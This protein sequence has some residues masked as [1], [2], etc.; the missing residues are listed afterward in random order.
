MTK[1]PDYTR[2]DQTVVFLLF[3][4]LFL[5]AALIAGL[6]ILNP[7]LLPLPLAGAVIAILV[8]VAHWREQQLPY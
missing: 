4:N 5:W 7:I 2:P 6:L 1:H 3:V 8:L